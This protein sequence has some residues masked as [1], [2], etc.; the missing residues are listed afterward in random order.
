VTRASSI[1]LRVL[2]LTI[3]MFVCFAVGSLVLGQSSGAEPS[4][5]S[6]AVALPLLTVCLLNTIVLAHVILRS[7]WG[8]WKLIAAVFFVFYGTM[9]FMSQIESAVFITTLPPGLLPRI[10][11][12]GVLIAA[13][14]S[15]LAVLI[16]GKKRADLASAERNTR[17][18]MTPGDWAWKVAVLA[19]A[20]VLLYFTF[21]YFI[22]W[23]NPTLREYYGGVD[24][25]GFLVHM[26]TVARDTPWVFP[27]QVLRGLFWI[28]I[29]LP[30]V[31]M[32]RGGWQETAVAVGLV[33]AV[34]MTAQLLLPNPYMPETV[35]MT[36]LVETASSNFLFGLLVGWLLTRGQPLPA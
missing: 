7:R 31:R 16:L 15:M 9:T 11:L 21:G 3:V 24:E 34:L 28:A 8:G 33:F 25:G 5:Q 13:P 12:M 6:G 17:L 36:H 14:F 4:E 1:V 35:R 2:A 26:G 30:L 18:V 19:A 29:A 23:Q 32:M 22:A 20:Y 10:F 27:F